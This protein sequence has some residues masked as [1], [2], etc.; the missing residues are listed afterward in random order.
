VNQLTLAPLSNVDI[1]AVCAAAIAIVAFRARSLSATGAVAAFVV[2]TA[3]YG[4]LAVPGAAVLLAFFVTS[5]ALSRVGKARKKIVL[6]DVGKTGARDAAQVFANGG[7]AALCAVLALTVDAR[8][9]YAFAGAFAAATA[10]TWGTEIGTLVRSAPRSI[11][12]LRPIA[13]GLSGGITLAGS[14]AEL[15]GALFVGAVATIVR[16]DAFAPVACAGIA[17]ALADSLL[18]AS[19]Q[20]L[21]WCPNCK[22]ATEREPHTC[23]AN[24]Q[25]F[26]GLA[27]FGNDAVNF[28]ATLVGAAAAFALAR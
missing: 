1:G 14:A 5:V 18:G 27:W 28:S 10:D 24:T 11:L 17:G 6:A 4:A 21:R 8:Y 16:H 12:T 23:G 26:R 9:A 15:A 20:S 3:T 7:V 22:R 13:T 19:L 2:G 25:P